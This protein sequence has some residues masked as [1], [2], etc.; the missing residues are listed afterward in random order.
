MNRDSSTRASAEASPSYTEPG[1]WRGFVAK[2]VTGL[3]LSPFTGTISG[4]LLLVAGMFLIVAWQAGP[5]HLVDASRLGK[6]TG[7]TNGTILESSV[8]V[9]WD[10]AAVR[11][12]RPVRALPPSSSCAVG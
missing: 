6:L 11:A 2:Q 8:A 12:R 1:R 5:Q 10:P 4:F 9:D 7:P 3:V